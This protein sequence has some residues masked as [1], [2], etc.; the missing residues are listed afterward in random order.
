MH[1][2][3]SLLLTFL[4]LGALAF[5]FFSLQ[6][7]RRD[8]RHAEAASLES[9]SLPGEE[10]RR[11]PEERRS[12]VL[13]AEGEGTPEPPGSID[14][15][16]YSRVEVQVV[17]EAGRAITGATISSMGEF[18]DTLSDPRGRAMLRRPRTALSHTKLVISKEG[19]VPVRRTVDWLSPTVLVRLGSR[20]QIHGRVADRFGQP[21]Q[22]E[23]LVI[24]W[25]ALS[26]APSPHDIED[27]YL[28]RG[29]LVHVFAGSDGRFE[30]DDASSI[31][32][33]FLAAGSAGYLTPN[34]TPVFGD[35]MKD[36]IVLEAEKVFGALL[37]FQAADGDPLVLSETTMRSR[38]DTWGG[39]IPEI[40][41]ISLG[42]T[43][44]TLARVPT[45][46]LD[47]PGA[48]VLCLYSC[49]TA[50]GN[51]IGPCWYRGTFPGY[52]AVDLTFEAT[53]LEF[54]LTELVCS[55]SQR[56]EG[57]GNIVLLPHGA[58]DDLRRCCSTWR[59]ALISLQEKT[60][61]MMD[62]LAVDIDLARE[63]IVPEIPAGR[64]FCRIESVDRLLTL[65]PQESEPF[66]IEVKDGESVT[67]E[68]PLE[69][70]GAISIQ[71]LDED[72]LLHD[73]YLRLTAAPGLPVPQPD[74]RRFL[75]GAYPFEFAAPPY[76]IPLMRAG[77][78][79][80]RG[81]SPAWDLTEGSGGFLTVDVGPGEVE[82]LT[83][84]AK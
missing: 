18:P 2:R 80:L 75:L 70:V 29:G 24:L 3:N 38:F 25:E 34:G 73:G 1:S 27:A 10:N 72:G 58:T 37:R 20:A 11:T 19:F 47:S 42:G 60:T 22:R 8:E 49:P 32:R 50:S 57:R 16:E 54:G 7:T 44:A 84:L 41:P 66:D 6:W 31:G 30:I 59:N 64:Y 12:P 51:S 17:D 61:S 48:K 40:R 67:V 52:D 71:L 45:S 56:K 15:S 78:Y 28:D 79:T 55:L 39:E 21:I 43:G 26:E 69:G 13:P 68:L 77:T 36:E 76:R 5:L 81:E 65:P 9:S 4:A 74:G 33:Y 62:T 23:F 35:R 46:L 14:R 82:R 53:S 83:V 63:S